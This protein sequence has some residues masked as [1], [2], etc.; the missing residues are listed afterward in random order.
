MGEVAVSVESGITGA[1]T[2]GQV[3]AVRARQRQFGSIRK[4]PSGRF[5]AR[6]VEPSGR[7]ST[8]PVTFAIKGDAARYP[9]S[10]E[11]D[12]A[13]GT[14]KGRA[15][16]SVSVRD[17]GC[18]WLARPGK[19]PASVVR[20]RQ[21]LEVWLPTLG[22]RVLSAVSAYD[23]QVAVDARASEVAPSTLRRD[24]ATL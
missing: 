4:L 6:F 21:A 12:L 7:R 1:K 19:R 2:E 3:G 22:D 8:A 16:V 15:P 18:E 9:A 14:F 23:V 13:R 20:D 17:W 5:R 10:I 24:F 11:A